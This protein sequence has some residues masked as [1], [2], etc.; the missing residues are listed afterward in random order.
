MQLPPA[1][2]LRC[3]GVTQEQVRRGEWQIARVTGL[4]YALMLED[5]IRQFSLLKRQEEAAMR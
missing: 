4:M 3:I 5:H 2:K 1:Q